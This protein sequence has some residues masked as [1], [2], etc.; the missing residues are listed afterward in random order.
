[1][2]RPEKD[3]NEIR[4]YSQWK[5]DLLDLKKNELISKNFDELLS[6][7]MDFPIKIYASRDEKLELRMEKLNRSDIFS[8]VLTFDYLLTKTSFVDDIKEILKTLS[9]AYVHPVDIEFTINFYDDEPYKINLLQC[10]PFQVKT[11][12][13]N[14]ATPEEINKNSI[15][16]KSTGPILGNGIS[17][18]IDFIIY[19]EPSEY[20]GMSLEDRYAIARL[21][22]KLNF[23]FYKEDKKFVLIGPGRWGSSSPHLGISVNF[24]EINNSLG[25]CEVS[26]MHENLVP[27]ISLGTHFFNDLVERDINYFAVNPE[28]EGYLIKR[29][30]FSNYQN[31]LE[32]YDPESK[33][34]GHVVKVINFNK[35]D[36][37]SL[38]IYMNSVKQI[39]YIYYYDKK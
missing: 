5:V 37:K 11:E 16:I 3:S 8:Q 20:S 26:Q 13:V 14:I 17:S 35:K 39:G 27:D 22:G 19:I 21:I 33:D 18:E 30:F 12:S 24:A 29:S 6:N 34:L 36:N 10:R 4:K 9:E 38:H 23:K 31:Q 1:M 15:I 28:Q 25:I 7:S 32:K 2:L